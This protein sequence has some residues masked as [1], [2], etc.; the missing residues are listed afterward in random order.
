MVKSR[1]KR[2]TKRNFSKKR[3]KRIKRT[4]RVNK[5]GKKNRTRK[6]N[7]KGSGFLKSLGSK[8]KKAAKIIGSKT[9]EGAKI[10]GYQG[11]L[12]STQANKLLFENKINSIRNW[13]KKMEELQ[14]K[15]N[16]ESLVATPSWEKCYTTP[17]ENIT[18]NENGKPIKIQNYIDAIETI[19]K[20][21]EG[22]RVQREANR[23]AKKELKEKQQQA[24]PVQAAPVQAAPVQQ[25]PQKK[26]KSTQILSD[27]ID[28]VLDPITGL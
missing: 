4:Q 15:I 23:T 18:I 22:R 11:R 8:T 17:K 2:R 14:P 16:G 9:K 1:S 28:T 19:K 27:V 25:E 13:C 20:E 10:V 3:P 21:E 12:K 24:A 7:Q 6:R 5:K 26:K